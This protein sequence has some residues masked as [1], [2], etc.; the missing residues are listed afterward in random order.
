MLSDNGCRRRRAQFWDR[1]LDR[2][3]G[4]RIDGPLVLANPIHLMYLANFWVDPF[5]L[6]AGFGGY[7]LFER[8]GHAALVHDNRLPASAD[9]AHVDTREVVD[10][11]DGRSPAGP[12]QLAVP[13]F[14]EAN[15]PAHDQPGHRLCRDVIDVLAGMRRSKW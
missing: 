11:Y 15:L 12:R 1:L 8:A 10:W 2:I 5:S 6:G 3:P 4:H 13:E 14:L 7:L 9:S